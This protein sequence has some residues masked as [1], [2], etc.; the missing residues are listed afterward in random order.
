MWNLRSVNFERIHGPV[1]PNKMESHGTGRKFP[2]RQVSVVVGTPPIINALYYFL[3]DYK[4]L[5]L[6]LCESTIQI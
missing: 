1:K 2:F 6:T 4:I 5:H 3:R